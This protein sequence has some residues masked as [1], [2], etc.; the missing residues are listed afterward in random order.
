MT[1][2]EKKKIEK[3]IQNFLDSMTK[4]EFQ[5]SLKKAGLDFYKNVK[6]RVFREDIIIPRTN[7]GF[8]L[9]F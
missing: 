3:D 9:E 4:E 1:T 2:E 8:G 5:D 7:A 6:Q